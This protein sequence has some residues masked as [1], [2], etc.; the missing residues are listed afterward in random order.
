MTTL[1]MSQK[2]VLLT[3]AQKAVLLPPLSLVR[4]LPHLRTRAQIITA[5]RISSLR[6]VHGRMSRCVRLFKT[7]RR[8]LRQALALWRRSNVGRVSALRLLCVCQT[9]MCSYEHIARVA[10]AQRRQLCS[11]SADDASA[12]AYSARVS[13]LHEPRH[14]CAQWLTFTSRVHVH[15]KLSQQAQGERGAHS[16]S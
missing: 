16:Y 6:G 5:L 15:P 2:A 13:T 3:M 7:L 9:Q 12:S 4:N 1:T 10:C 11:Q 14:A 8:A